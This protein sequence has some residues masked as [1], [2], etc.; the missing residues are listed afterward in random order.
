MLS[1]P[2]YTSGGLQV[3]YMLSEKYFPL[4]FSN[5]VSNYFYCVVSSQFVYLFFW[6]EFGHFPQTE[7]L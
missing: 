4:L 6:T 5:L 1:V 7:Q 3:P 2:V